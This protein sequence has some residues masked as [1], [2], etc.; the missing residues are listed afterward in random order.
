MRPACGNKHAQHIDAIRWRK[1]EA[2]KAAWTRMHPTATP[3]QYHR[4]LAEIAR[5]CGV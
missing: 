4:A 1:Y 2:M 5:R 3:E